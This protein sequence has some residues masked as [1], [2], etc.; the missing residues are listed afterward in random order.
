MKLC[1]YSQ[2]KHTKVYLHFSSSCLY[3]QLQCPHVVRLLHHY[4]TASRIFLLLEY[5]K[6]G[7]LIHFVSAKREQWEKL[8]RAAVEPH[9]LATLAG[10]EES[11]KAEVSSWRGEGTDGK[12]GE[13]QPNES[14][15][16]PQLSASPRDD[17]HTDEM[18][19]ML[20]ELA[21]IVPPSDLPVSS[22]LEV[23]ESDSDVACDS[24]DRLALMRKQLEES[25]ATGTEG[26]DLHSRSLN[27]EH[28]AANQGSKEHSLVTE[29]T[30]ISI[31][32]PTP[33]TPGQ[34]P[35]VPHPLSTMSDSDRTAVASLSVETSSQIRK[36]QTDV[37][38]NYGPTRQPVGSPAQAIPEG[39]SPTKAPSSG[40]S[41]PCFT[42]SSL[43]NSPDAARAAVDDWSR[44]LEDTVRQWAWQIVG[45]LDHLHA[46]GVICRYGT[47][48]IVLHVN[49]YQS[50]KIGVYILRLWAILLRAALMKGMGIVKYTIFI[51][52][53]GHRLQKFNPR[54][55]HIHVP[56]LVLFVWVRDSTCCSIRIAR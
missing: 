6:G 15:E 8:K 26:S 35:S 14:L 29:G 38:E 30:V 55:I 40:H 50:H 19:Q 45:A 32:P 46:Q 54:I 51:F 36:S 49:C 12:G 41:S 23:E 44:R 52:A 37:L 27:R 25:M 21:D 7:R 31:E 24:L 56:V 22:E 1:I 34:E 28:T 20:M 3:L 2:V 10:K 42:P 5:V 39:E 33:T 43:R 47:T 18:E 4:Q 16:D 9:P 17:A 48:L 13:I 11:E 53:V